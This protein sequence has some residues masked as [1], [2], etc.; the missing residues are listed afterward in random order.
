MIV[1]LQDIVWDTE[2]EDVILP[3]SVMIAELFPN[4]HILT[5]AEVEDLMDT[6]S[7][8]FGWCIDSATYICHDTV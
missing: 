3:S 1:E 8:R 7:Q 4:E 5:N 2:G 6:V